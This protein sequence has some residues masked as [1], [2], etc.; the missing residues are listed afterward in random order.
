MSA[1]GK[2]QI[3]QVGQR[4]AII[5]STLAQQALAAGQKMW[6]LMP[7][8]HIF[9]HLCEWQAGEF[10]NPRSYWTYADEDLV[11][12]LVECAQSCH[13]MTVAPSALFKWVHVHFN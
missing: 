10:G 6:K 7:K 13:A 9:V 1:A 5:Y 8:L 4:L 2:A 3:A 11:G 12:L